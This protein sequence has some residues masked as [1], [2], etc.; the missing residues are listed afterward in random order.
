MNKVIL[1][2]NIGKLSAEY[3]PKGQLVAKGTL[4]VQ[5][6]YGNNKETDWYD[7]VVWGNK[8][9]ET[10]L[11]VNFNNLC[12]VGTQVLIVGNQRIKKWETERSK[13]TSV[14]VTVQEFEVLRNGKDK[15]DEVETPFDGK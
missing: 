14:E 11:G 2:G 7:L 6:G 1:K 9:G 3:T 8:D 12:K 13:G 5:V 4:A 10:G 15:E